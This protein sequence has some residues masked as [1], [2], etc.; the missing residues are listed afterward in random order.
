MGII[1]CSFSTGKVLKAYYVKKVDTVVPYTHSLNLLAEKCS[2]ELNDEQV[3]L[4]EDVTRFNVE[5]RYPSEKFEFHKICA[6]EYTE[7][8][9]KKIKDFYEWLLRKF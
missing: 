1:C 9:L 8:Y 7:K 6:K 5:A 3:E 4:L 2:L